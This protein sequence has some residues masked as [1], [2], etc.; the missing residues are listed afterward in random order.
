MTPNQIKK[1]VAK[2]YEVEYADI[3]GSCREPKYILPRH[4]AMFLVRDLLGL[5]YPKIG[6]RFRGHHHTTVMYAVKKIAGKLNNPESGEDRLIGDQ[7]RAI[8]A[9]LAVQDQRG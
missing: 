5:S 8:K 6:Y 3:I 7:A 4:M 1:A 9:R 2:Y